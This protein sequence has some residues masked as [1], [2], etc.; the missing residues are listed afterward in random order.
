MDK[1]FQEEQQNLSGIERKIDDIIAR[2]LPHAQKCAAEQI[3]F[4]IYDNEDRDRL[5]QLRREQAEMEQLVERY[6]A[7]KPSPYFGRLD[8]EQEEDDHVRT[9]TCYIGNDAISDGADGFLNIDEAQDLSV[10]EYRLLRMVLGRDCVFNLY[11]DVNQTVYSYKGITDWGEIEDSF[12]NNVYVLNENYRN[13]QQITEFCN[14]EFDAEIYAIGVSGPPVEERSAEEAVRRVL[15]IKGAEPECRAAILYRYGLK[16]IQEL[17]KELLPEQDVSWNSVDPKKISVL[18]V[19]TA[20][21]LEFDVVVAIVDQMSI[22]ETYISYTRAMGRLIVVRD[23]FSSA[24]LPEDGDVL[25]EDDAEE[26]EI[27]ETS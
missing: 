27:V 10:S 18:S 20:K 3:D 17:L 7:Y 9:V 8:L 2:Y 15:E 24:M 12:A 4:R 22:N 21:G 11:G 16:E 5:L 6:R 14:K 1:I 13:T 19:E 25:E 26:T 23:Q